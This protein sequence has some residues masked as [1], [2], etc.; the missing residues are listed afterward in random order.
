VTPD[1]ALRTSAGVLRAPFLWQ[2]Y[3]V[4]TA[5]TGARL[6]AREGTFGLWQPVT[7]PPLVVL[8][9]GRYFDGWLA[10]RGQVTVWPEAAHAT[11]GTLTFTISLPRHTQPVVIRIG[12]RLMPVRPGSRVRLRWPIDGPQPRTLVFRALRGGFTADLRQRN[13]R[14]SMPRFS[15]S[16]PVGT[17]SR[18][19][20]KPIA[21]RADS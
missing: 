1:G 11:S 20:L 9:T 3:G 16:R 2:G 19:G 21:L 7:T 8:A 5:F 18:A 14:A 15:P 12:N 10:W 4:S 6:V 13:V 17:T